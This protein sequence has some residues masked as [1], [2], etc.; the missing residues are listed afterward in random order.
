M[1]SRI[2]WRE[3]PYHASPLTVAASCKAIRLHFVF[4]KF[5]TDYRCSAFV[6]GST[7]SADLWTQS[8]LGT[9]NSAPSGNEK[10]FGMTPTI[11]ASC[12]FTRNVLPIEAGFP[13]NFR[14]QSG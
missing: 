9:H 4:I 12:P 7:K 10:P 8:Y 13:L 3:S 14:C 1:P 6:R 11:T 5:G 2:L